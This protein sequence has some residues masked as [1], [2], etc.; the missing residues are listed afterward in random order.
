MRRTLLGIAVGLTVATLGIQP[1]LADTFTVS[2]IEV[3][4]LQRVSAGSV[5][6]S[7]PINIGEEIDSTELAAAIKSCSSISAT[8]VTISP[9]RVL[10]AV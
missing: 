4:G 7:F 1:A 3:E 8:A 10:M 9:R 5:F 2:D 6:A